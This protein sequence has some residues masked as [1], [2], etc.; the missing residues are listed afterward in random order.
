MHPL[1]QH[2]TS[3]PQQNN[4]E[5]FHKNLNSPAQIFAANKPILEGFIICPALFLHMLA[6]LNSQLSSGYSGLPPTTLHSVES[7][8]KAKLI[9]KD[10]Y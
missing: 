5:T 2:N 3:H 6:K 7:L 10:H 9:F 8:D 1:T 4:T